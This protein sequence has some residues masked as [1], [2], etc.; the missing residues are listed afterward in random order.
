[1][2]GNDIEITVDV[3]ISRFV[4]GSIFN[5]N[6]VP[7][8]RP[9]SRLHRLYNNIDNTNPRIDSIDGIVRSNQFSAIASSLPGQDKMA[10][11]KQNDLDPMEHLL[12]RKKPL[13]SILL[14]HV[15]KGMRVSDD[16]KKHPHHRVA[17]P[18]LSQ[19]QSI[20]Q[21]EF[22][23]DPSDS[24]NGLS[25]SFHDKFSQTLG[26]NTD[27][28]IT[29]SIDS[30]HTGILPSNFSK[31]DSSVTAGA[32]GDS[33]EDWNLSIASILSTSDNHPQQQAVSDSG[34]SGEEIGAVSIITL[35]VPFILCSNLLVILSVVRFRRLHIPTNYFIASLASVDVLVALATP[36]MIMVEVFQFGSSGATVGC[37]GALL[38]LLPNRILMMACGVS[39][40]T[41][42]TIAYD[43]HTAL[44][45]PLDYV[46]IMTSRRVGV[47]VLLTWV[48]SA[49]IVWLPMLAGWHDSPTHLVQCSADLL[50]GKAHALFLSAI[51]LPSCIVI[52]VCYARIF[53]LAHHHAQAIAAVEFAVHR[54]L[55][56]KIMIKDAK[57]AKTLALVIGV[58]LALWLPFLV[59]MFVKLVA[60]VTLSIWVQ[61]Y[62]VL[63]AVLNSGINPWIYAFKNKEFRHAFRRLYRE[64]FLERM[65]LRNFGRRMSLAHTTSGCTSTPRLS[66]TDSRMA[67]A[68]VDSATLDKVCE[69]LQRSLDSLDR[70]DRYHDRRLGE[71]CRAWR[72]GPLPGPY[73]ALPRGKTKVKTYRQ[74]L[75]C[76]DLHDTEEMTAILSRSLS[77]EILSSSEDQ[78]LSSPCDSIQSEQAHIQLECVD[79]TCLQ[80][81]STEQNHTTCSGDD[82]SLN[83]PTAITFPSKSPFHY[84]SSSAL[85]T[86][87]SANICS[88]ISSPVIS[89]PLPS[90]SLSRS[91]QTD[92][93]MTRQY[94]PA[95]LSLASAPSNSPMTCN[96]PSSSSLGTKEENSPLFARK[97]SGTILNSCD[98]TVVFVNEVSSDSSPTE[99]SS[100]SCLNLSTDSFSSLTP[101]STICSTD[102]PSLSHFTRMNLCRDFYP[103]P[104]SLSCTVELRVP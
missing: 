41:L 37:S 77:A 4:L 74:A 35:M 39:L 72:S 33:V 28:S 68:V 62:L 22:F 70:F 21:S 40:L 66:T 64:V 14:S 5:L 15:A 52:L 63:V 9:A 80:L 51:F 67:T 26:A 53:S 85:V 32:A 100:P 17:P 98:N 104:S 71:Q 50:H 1:M 20:Q 59:S 76:S 60:G 92:R 10:G 57:Y 12:E 58:F 101:S 103:E 86:A 61:T 45:S 42:A 46:V 19:A 38:C 44:V 83:S 56:V 11:E 31:F 65:C 96:M 95:T 36:F 90:S 23:S 3:D 87:S 88:M 24:V 25:E 18:P 78:H 8:I 93:N 73:R 16:L 29:D 99:T 55:Q 27:K 47:L 34:W 97:T 102:E 79:Q 75:S 48:Y 30:L 69:K 84:I 13:S 91:S 6:N 82:I 2:E 43:R 81:I 7:E 49:L 89:S 94:C 54:R